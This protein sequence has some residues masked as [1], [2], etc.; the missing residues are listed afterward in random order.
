MTDKDINRLLMEYAEFAM[1]WKFRDDPS[2]YVSAN[3][4]VYYQQRPRK[5]V[6][7]DGFIVRGVGN[8]LRDVYVIWEEGGRAPEVVFEFVARAS[9]RMDPEVK[10][11]IYEQIGVLEYYVFD[12][13]ARYMRPPFRA[14]RL[15]GG[16]F[17][18][19]PIIDGEITSPILGL[20]MRADGQW[21]RFHDAASGEYIPPPI[22]ALE[23]AG[24]QLKAEG[25]RA[26]AE[27]ERARALEEEVERLRRQL[28]KQT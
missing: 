10:K 13:K 26:R 19:V 3:L 21:L 4:F 20:R 2:V 11:E 23:A 16:R 6:S 12:P 27:A 15:H 25:E 18:E 14:F 7:P 9:Y 8:H 24:R 22:E 17:E 1:K 28:G 5:R